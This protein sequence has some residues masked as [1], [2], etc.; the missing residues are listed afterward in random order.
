MNTYT[1]RGQSR[2]QERDIAAVLRTYAVTPAA[3]FVALERQRGYQAE[4]EMNWLTKE[5]GVTAQTR[6]S[7]VSRLRQMIGAALVRAGDRLAGIPRSGVSPELASAAAG[8]H[9]GT[10]TW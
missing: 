5:N 4:A 7:F 3:S 8:T 2:I 1:P 9:R 10:A 6:T